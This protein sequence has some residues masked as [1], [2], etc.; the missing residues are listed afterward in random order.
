MLLGPR[1]MEPVKR[2]IQTHRLQMEIVVFNSHVDWDH[3]WG[4][5][6][7]P[8]HL[9]I[10]YELCW[11]INWVCRLPSAAGTVGHCAGKEI[12]DSAR[13]GAEDVD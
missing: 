2:H 4:N 1:P 12:S 8:G 9:I 5:C 13:T 10:G 7:F 3:V 6:D 11:L